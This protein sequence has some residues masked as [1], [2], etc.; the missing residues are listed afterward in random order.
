[1][2]DNPFAPDETPQE[3]GGEDDPF[4]DFLNNMEAQ[5]EF[6]AAQSVTLRSTT[7]QSYTVPIEGPTPLS[8]VLRRSNLAFGANI[9]LWVNGARVEPTY[10]V[11]PGA[12]VTAVGMVKGG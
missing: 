4:D 7:G 2:S 5:P 10:E 6:D 11:A 8:E 3:N 9:E 12:V 1:M